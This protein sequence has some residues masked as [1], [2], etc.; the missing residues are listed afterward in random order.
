MLGDQII[1]PTVYKAGTNNIT[2]DVTG[3]ANGVY[4]VKIQS[5]AGTA[6]KQLTVSH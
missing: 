1:E 4:L 3:V 2:L 6:I 5:A